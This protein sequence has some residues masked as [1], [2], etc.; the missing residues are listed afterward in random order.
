MKLT[1]QLNLHKPEEGVWGDCFRT[2]LACLLNLDPEEVPHFN[3][4]SDGRNDEDVSREVNKW[5]RKQGLA[6]ISV[7]FTGET[8]IEAV[9]A[10]ADYGSFGL[11]FLLSGTSRTGVD[12]V[13]ICH[14]GEIVWD[15]SQVDSGII[16]PMAN[17]QWLVEWLVRPAE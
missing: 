10:T 16:G 6:L 17:G 4:R 13:V 3:D 9:L 14:R 1:K 15:P 2:A 7:F 12:H 8:P 5:I 11:P